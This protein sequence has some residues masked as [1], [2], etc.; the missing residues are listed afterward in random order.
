M[1][2]ITI[3]FGITLLLDYFLLGFFFKFIG[4]CSDRVYI[5]CRSNFCLIVVGKVRENSFE[6]GV[7]GS[8]I[9]TEEG[10]PSMEPLQR[11]GDEGSNSI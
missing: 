6:A 4:Q 1:F 7:E 8:V 5:L 3:T 2:Y 11:N 10:I 9:C